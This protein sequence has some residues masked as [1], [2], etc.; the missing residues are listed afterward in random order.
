MN[1]RDGQTDGQIDGVRGR[2]R[3][4]RMEEID[5]QTDRETGLGAEYEMIFCHSRGSVF[6]LSGLSLYRVP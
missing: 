5:S 2:E 4:Q 3:R 1:G 6:G